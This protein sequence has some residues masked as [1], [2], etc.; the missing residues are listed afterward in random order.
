MCLP[1][2]PSSLVC[3][4]SSEETDAATSGGDRKVLKNVFYVASAVALP[5][6]AWSEVVT[7]T[8]GEGLQGA[9]LGGLEGISYLVLLGLVG[10]SIALKV[11]TGTGLPAGPYGLIGAMEGIAYLEVVGF[12]LSQIFHK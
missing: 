6:V 4:A 7:F 10:K 1:S 8:T 9:L 11:R 12:I 3:R 5:I 2:S